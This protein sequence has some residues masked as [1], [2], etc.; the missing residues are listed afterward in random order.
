MIWLKDISRLGDNQQ[1][2]SEIVKQIAEQEGVPLIDLRKAFMAFP[3]YTKLLCDDGIHPNK[4]GQMVILN[5]IVEFFK[6]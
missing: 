2:Y 5:S 6:I 4:D 1:R 3:D